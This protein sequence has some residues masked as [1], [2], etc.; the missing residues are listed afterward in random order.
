M[1]SSTGS[2]RVVFWNT[3]LLR[4][5]LWSGGPSLPFTDQLFA[6][7]VTKRAPMIGQALAGRFDVCALAEVFDSHEQDV[8]ATQW[9][10]AEFQ[11]GP[12]A[13]FPKRMGSG[14]MTLVDSTKVEVVATAAH[15]FASGG[16][17]RDADSF[18]TK[19]ALLTRVRTDGGAEL[20]VVSTHLLAGGDWIPLPGG[21]DHARHHRARMAQV[22][23]LVQFVSTER[24]HENPLLLMGDF[25]VAAHDRRLPDD[26][27]AYY[28]DL[29][30]RLA[31]LDVVDL[32]AEQGVGD[33]LTC[34][35]RNESEIEQDDAFPDCVVDAV[36][37]TGQEN[38]PPGFGDRIDYIWYSKPWR[39]SRTT[40]ETDRPRRWAFPGRGARGGPAGSL[41]D[42]LALSVTM[43]LKRR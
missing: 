12:T 17:L 25:N 28:R 22:D 40:V 21:G 10:E 6:P 36:P 27:G 30:D 34:S 32:W 24:N 23:E 41:S 31:E 33:G 4:P 38:E 19:G 15:E 43:H 20:D 39:R 13:S 29:T 37:P 18:A 1:G 5:R 42:H 3:W 7:D 2:V 14:L 26:P 9:D 8:V 16:D 35:F 11:P